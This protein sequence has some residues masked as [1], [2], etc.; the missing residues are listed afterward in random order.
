MLQMLNCS[1]WGHRCDRQHSSL[2]TPCLTFWHV[3]LGSRTYPL[4]H[5]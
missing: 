2:P 4:A 5:L 3:P 1:A